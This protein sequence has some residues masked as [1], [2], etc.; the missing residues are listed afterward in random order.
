MTTRLRLLLLAVLAAVAPLRAKPNAPDWLRK[1]AD[2]PVP[3]AFDA[4]AKAVVLHREVVYEV[5][6]DG[7]VVSTERAAVRILQPEGQKH[8][9]AAAGFHLDTDK[10]RTALAWLISPAGDPIAYAR[11]DFVELTPTNDTL[12]SDARTLHLNASGNAVAGATFGY[13]IS[14]ESRAVFSQF[15]EQLQG[16]LPILAQTIAVKLPGGWNLKSTFINH[17]KL[18]PVV[19]GG[20]FTWHIPP[21]LALPDEPFMP[22][23]RRLTALLGIDLL[24]PNAAA[25]AARLL[26]RFATWVDLSVY[27]SRLNDEAAVT[28]AAIVAKA[29]DLTKSANTP[30]DVVRALGRY[31]QKVNYI[32]IAANLGRGGGYKPRPAPLTLQ[33][34]FGDC[35]D[36]ASLLRALL[37]AKGIAAY[38]LSIYAGD[39]RAIWPEWPSPFQFN[40]AIIA[41][42]VP[43]DFPGP[44]VF[45]HPKFGRLLAFDPTDEDIPL[46]ELPA[47]H[48][49]SQ[50]LLEAGADGGLIELPPHPAEAFALRRTITAKLAATGALTARIAEQHHGH[51]AVAERQDLKSRTPDQYQKMTASWISSGIRGAKIANLRTEDR[52]EENG[53]SLSLELTAPAYG[54]SLRGKL[55]IFRPALI[56]RRRT[57]AFTETTRTQPILFSPSRVDETTTI[58]LPSNHIVDELPAP[59]ELRTAF[60]RY[61]S[62]CT[63]ADGVLKF[64]RQID[65]YAAEIPASDYETVRKFFEQV[66][67]AEQASAVL[68]RQA[69]QT[70]PAGPAAPP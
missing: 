63:A 70:A 24:V 57:T 54:Q 17:P 42:A 8:A 45:D 33:R 26:P 48:Y 6:P 52:F 15:I 47:S 4:K 55:L 60:A 18:E 25:G 46:G 32:S 20:V 38:P 40:H 12:F 30:G 37:R 2:T 36:K 29:A 65:Y 41:I 58:E 31:A 53:F 64:V 49:G 13:E 21:R 62:R 16:P 23:N 35:K 19:Q 28:D 3:A 69:P 44:A 1:A 68:Q 61:T 51:H 59:V 67:K 9:R 5:R 43:A 7:V 50:V 27:F 66:I 34:N 39:N 11:K 10:I 22:G 14:V 56:G